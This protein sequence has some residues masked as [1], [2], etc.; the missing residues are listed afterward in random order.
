MGSHSYVKKKFTFL[1]CDL[2]TGTNFVPHSR[3]RKRV[4]RQVSPLPP[5]LALALLPASGWSIIIDSSSEGSL[6]AE[7]CV[8]SQ[9]RKKLGDR[10]WLMY[11]PLH[12]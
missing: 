10:G 4:R 8:R 7:H 12:T 11:F 6:M 9:T 5:D 1:N 3:A 2:N